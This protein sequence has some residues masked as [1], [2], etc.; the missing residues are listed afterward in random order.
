MYSTRVTKK[1]TTLW[2][3]LLLKKKIKVNNYNMFSICKFSSPP[4]SDPLPHTKTNME[5]RLQDT[6]H[7]SMFL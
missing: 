3:C 6:I 4:S 5:S 2:Y 1:N 7:H